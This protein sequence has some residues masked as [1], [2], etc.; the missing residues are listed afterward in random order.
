MEAITN[1]LQKYRLLGFAGTAVLALGAIGFSKFM[2]SKAD[3]NWVTFSN[4]LETAGDLLVDGKSQG[5]LAPGAELRLVMEGGAHSVKLTSG[6]KTLDEGQLDINKKSY[7]AVYN[8]GGKPGLALVTVQ[9]GNSAIE[10]SLSPIPEGQRVIEVP[11]TF[12]KINDEFPDSLTTRGSVDRT[13]LT[14]VC[15]VEGEK[16]GC[17]GWE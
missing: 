4:S 7:H 17:P 14:N 11:M 3:E 8:V 10:N 6:D 2:A 5:S 9:Y 15:R 1:L 16:V 12:T 13:A